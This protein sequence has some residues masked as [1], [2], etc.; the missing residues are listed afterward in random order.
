M[1]AEIADQEMQGVDLSHLTTFRMS[2]S[3][4]KLFKPGDV[5]EFTEI[6]KSFLKVG[7]NFKVLGGGSNTII[8]N[9]KLPL[10][11]TSKLSKFKFVGNYVQAQVGVKLST[12]VK[13]AEKR[14]LSGIEFASGIPGTIGGAIFMNSGA[15]GGEISQCVEKV[16]VVDENGILNELDTSKLD[17]AYRSSIFHNQK[18][19]IT[20]CLLRLNYSTC[21]K[22][23]ERTQSFL[24]IKKRTQPLAMPSVGCIFKNPKSGYAAQLIDA[25]GLKGFKV[26]G[27]KV[28]EKHAGFFVNVGKATFENFEMVYN[29]VFKRVRDK[30]GVEL[31]PEITIIW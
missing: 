6:I 5:E 24:E 18:M 31:E 20:S 17:F 25:A 2:G 19:W 12:I 3:V 10:I 21:E 23:S 14:G 27:V 29:E 7:K 8:R 15:F 22:V 28:S 4:Q 1:Q 9:G 26:G 11:S 30:F 13:E 16:T